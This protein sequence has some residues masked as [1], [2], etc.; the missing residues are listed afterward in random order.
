MILTLISLL[1]NRLP[2]NCKFYIDDIESAWPWLPHEA[3]DYIHGRGMGGSI[4]DWPLLY[5]RA[6]EH[7]KVTHLHRLPTSCKLTS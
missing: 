1:S 6:L 7:L 4:S 2:P 5:S 3:F